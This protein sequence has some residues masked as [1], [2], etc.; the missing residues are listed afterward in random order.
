MGT[1]SKAAGTRNW[2][3]VMIIWWRV[4]QFMELYLYS[5]LRPLSVVS[6]DS[7]TAA[8]SQVDANGI[9]LRVVSIVDN[10]VMLK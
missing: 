3:L 7:Q 5:L 2:P 6:K 8:L 10:G 4:E 9:E 1:E